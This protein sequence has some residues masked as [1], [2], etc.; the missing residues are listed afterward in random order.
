MTLARPPPR[1]GTHSLSRTSFRGSAATEESPGWFRRGNDNGAEIT[2]SFSRFARE[3]PGWFHRGN[4]NALPNPC[5]VAKYAQLPCF[6]FSDAIR[7][8]GFASEARVEDST[9][10]AWLLNDGELWVSASAVGCVPLRGGSPLREDDGGGDDPPASAVTNVVQL[11]RPRYRRT[12][13]RISILTRHSEGAKRPKN[14][15]VGLYR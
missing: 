15:H 2:L 5:V 4:D 7:F 6:S 8:A 12:P 1:P 13:V 9:A 11:S 3:S 14:P 10:T